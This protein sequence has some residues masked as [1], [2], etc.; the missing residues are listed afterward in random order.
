MRG[1]GTHATSGPRARVPIHL[2]TTSVSN[3][4]FS[5]PAPALSGVC[6]PIV[7]QHP[8]TTCVKHGFC[9]HALFHAVALSPMPKIFDSALTDSNWRASMEEEHA[10]L[11]WNHTW[12]LVRIRPMP[13]LSSAN[14]NSCLTGHSSA[15]RPDGFFAALHNTLVWTSMR[16]LALL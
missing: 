12:A 8:I 10:A 2:H 1:L 13:T 7:N 3:A 11:L 6:S 16:L 15:T 5:A 14:T 4:C 9:Q